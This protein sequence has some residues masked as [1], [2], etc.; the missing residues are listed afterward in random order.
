MDQD[1]VGEQLLLVGGSE[2]FFPGLLMCY[3]VCP[4]KAWRNG[5]DILIFPDI[6]QC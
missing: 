4:A 3:N 5:V 1:T 2:R 6:F